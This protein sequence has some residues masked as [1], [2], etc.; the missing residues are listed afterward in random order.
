MESGA[1][2]D[3]GPLAQK[4]ARTFIAQGIKERNALLD[5]VHGELKDILPDITRAEVSDAITG[6][7]K[8]WGPSQDEVS[9]TL[10]DISRVKCPMPQ[11]T[12][13][14]F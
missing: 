7:G 4:L 2:A 5:A 8:F 13:S 3:I 10:R 6:R 1:E 12:N 11:D 9:I 14:K